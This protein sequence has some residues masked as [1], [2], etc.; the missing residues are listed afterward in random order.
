MMVNRMLFGL[1]FAAVGVLSYGWYYNN[2]RIVASQQEKIENFIK[3]GPRY[4]AED[5]KNEREERQQADQALCERI[6]KLER[7]VAG[8]VPL[9]DIHPLCTYYEQPAPTN[10]RILP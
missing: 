6:A 5:G 8:A 4:T 7:A 3:A 10:L 9:Y 2:Q 1:T